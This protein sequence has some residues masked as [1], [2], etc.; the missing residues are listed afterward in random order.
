M[1]R[2]Y[3]ITAEG[4]YDKFQ[5]LPASYD[6]RVLLDVYSSEVGCCQFASIA[7]FQAVV[8]T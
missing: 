1:K 3:A 8:Q 5:R 2:L 4:Y 7:D 6:R